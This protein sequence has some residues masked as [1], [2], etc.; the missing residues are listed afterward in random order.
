[1]SFSEL[2]VKIIVFQCETFINCVCNHQ[3]EIDV[4]DSVQGMLSVTAC[5]AE[6]YNGALLYNYC[7]CVPL[8]AL[9]SLFWLR[10]LQSITK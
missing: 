4:Q 9:K 3:G 2:E 10:N 5:R 8:F 1:M 7:N 6:K